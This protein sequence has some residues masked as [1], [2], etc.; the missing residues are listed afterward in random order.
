MVPCFPLLGLTPSGLFM[1]LS[2]T[3][4]YTSELILCSTICV[5]IATRHNIHMCE[6][7]ILSMTNIDTLFMTK[8]DEKPYA[9]GPHIPLLLISGSAPPPRNNYTYK[10]LFFFQDA[11][12]HVKKCK[13]NMQPTRGF[14]EQLSRWEEKMFGSIVTDISEPEY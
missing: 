9:L 14:F 11:Y 4:I 10:G 3:L 13:G 12:N 7:Y 2:S 5:P 6:N 8:T 1:G